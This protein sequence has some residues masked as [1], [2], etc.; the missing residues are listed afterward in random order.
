MKSKGDIPDRDD[1]RPYMPGAEK[2]LSELV[3]RGETLVYLSGSN[4]AVDEPDYELHGYDT[5]IFKEKGW[6]YTQNEDEDEVWFS[7]DA[8]IAFEQH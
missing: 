5:H 3:E 8:I 1:V 6:V 7:I 2:V 4:P